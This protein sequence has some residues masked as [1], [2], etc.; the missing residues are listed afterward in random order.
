MPP[1]PGQYEIRYVLAQGD[2]LL[3]ARPITVIAATVSLEAP[4]E[5]AVGETI[6]VVWEGPD[7]SVGGR[8]INY[9]YTDRGSPASIKMPSKPGNYEIR[10]I[11]DQGKTTLFTRSI[12]VK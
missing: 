8:Y 1:K 12:T 7:E 6:S 10:Y 4:D 5:A 3:A 9:A 11:L 2:T